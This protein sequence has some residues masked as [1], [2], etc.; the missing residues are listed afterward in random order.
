MK[1][2]QVIVA[3]GWAGLCVFSDAGLRHGMLAADTF[4][5]NERGLRVDDGFERLMVIRIEGVS[6]KYWRELTD[7]DTFGGG[8]FTK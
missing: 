3:H 2:K 1:K 7:G 8:T 5:I 4:E 6:E